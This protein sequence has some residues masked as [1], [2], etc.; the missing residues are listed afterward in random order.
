MNDE[1]NGL[2]CSRDCKGFIILY[3]SLGSYMLYNDGVLLEDIKEPLNPKEL[4]KNHHLEILIPFNEFKANDNKYPTF[5]IIFNHIAETIGEDTKNQRIIMTILVDLIRTIK[6]AF[7]EPSKNREFFSNSPNEIIDAARKISSSS[8]KDISVFDNLITPTTIEDEIN[9]RANPI[10]TNEEKVKA[11]A[12]ANE[13]NNIGLLPYLD[14]IL[15]DIHIGNHKNIYRKILAEFNVM[16]GKGSYLMETT[17][18]A[19]AGKSFEDNI[20]FGLITPQ[21]YIFEVNDITM[22]GFSRYALI[23][24]RYFD[25]VTINFGDCGSSK[26][27]KK[28]EDIFNSIKPL[29]TEGKYKYIRSDKDNDSNII[30]QPL[31]VKSIGAVYQTTKN[32]FTEDDDQLISRTLFSTPAKVELKNIARQIF[33]LFDDRTRQSKSKSIAE[34]KLQDFGLYLMQMVNT[35][36]K[37]INPYF[38]VFWEYASKSENPLREITQQMELF[39]AYC[40]LTN[41]KCK[42]EPKSTLFASEEQLKEFM[43]YINL[44]N[45]LIPYE[46]DFLE[47]LLAKGKA[48][49]LTILY[50]DFDLLDEEGNLVDADL[51]EITTLTECENGAIELINSQLRQK[52]RNKLKSDGYSEDQINKKLETYEPIKTKEDLNSQQLKELPQKLLNIYGF[53]SPSASQRIFFRVNDIKHYYSKRSAYKNIDNV[54]QLLQTLHNK[55][56]LGKYEYKHNKENLYYLTPLCNNLTS[57]FEL[58]KSYDRYVTDYFADTGYENF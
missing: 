15:Q 57:D 29:I 3:D 19:E 44:E 21:K 32:S 38:D 8:G 43:D 47:M 24:P 34:Q 58:K 4:H 50:N 17:A 45:A 48:K 33:Y 37:V 53:R 49:E 36:I 6:D 55:G 27:F 51:N 54:P 31:R 28:K 30:E 7:I 42:R 16:R 40:I 18:K 41:T 35:D 14:N 25:R 10:L 2:Y 1:Y 52:Y 9:A 12:I 23:N 56:Y 39:D 5:E 26:S 22:A 46:Y 11:D 13:V 20:V